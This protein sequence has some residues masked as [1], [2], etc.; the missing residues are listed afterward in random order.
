MDLKLMKAF[1]WNVRC[2]DFFGSWPRVV[3]ATEW[4]ACTMIVLGQFVKSKMKKLK[5]KQHKQTM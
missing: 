4:P 5:E 1:R 2:I 3:T